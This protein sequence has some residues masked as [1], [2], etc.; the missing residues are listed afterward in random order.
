V[1]GD[2]S[3]SEQL[4]FSVGDLFFN[5]VARTVTREANK[6]K[7]TGKEYLLLLSLARHMLKCAGPA[8][9]SD[10]EIDMYGSKPPGSKTIAVFVHH[11]R[12]KLREAESIVFIETIHGVGFKLGINVPELPPCNLVE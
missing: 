1:V 5:T 6:I 12:K 10:I 2:F 4:H 9:A 8:H 7:F 3:K 11:V